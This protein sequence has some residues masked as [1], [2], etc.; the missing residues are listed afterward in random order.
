MVY[1]YLGNL[2]RPITSYG[3]HLVG[4][5]IIVAYRWSRKQKLGYDVTIISD[6]LREICADKRRYRNREIN[7]KK[8]E[9]GIPIKIGRPWRE[10]ARPGPR[11][12]KGQLQPTPVINKTAADL[13]I[14]VPQSEQEPDSRM[15]SAM[16]SNAT[17]A[18]INSVYSFPYSC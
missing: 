9:A 12:S 14:Q 17:K 4:K 2:D 5:A 13:E 1:L 10:K 6:L 11:K 15:E 18:H 16:V 7:Q 3:K 8:K